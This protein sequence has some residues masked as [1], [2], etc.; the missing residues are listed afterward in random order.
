M[1]K[2]FDYWKCFTST[3]RIDDYLHYIACTREE[4]T[5]E[6]AKGSDRSKE[7]GLIAGIDYSNGDGSVGHAGW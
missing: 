3:G 5:D 6:P 7:G 1:K 4:G 2:K